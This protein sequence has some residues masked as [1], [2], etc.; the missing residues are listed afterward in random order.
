V[1]GVGSGMQAGRQAAPARGD[2]A[3]ILAVRLHSTGEVVVAMPMLFVRR[4][5]AALAAL[6]SLTALPALPA[7][8]QRPIDG[9]PQLAQ[10]EQCHALL[11]SEPQASL[12]LARRL[13]E[14]PSLSTS[15]EIGAVGCLGAALRGLGQLEQDSALPDRLLAAAARADATPADRQRARSMAAHLLLWSGER[16]RALSLTGGLLDDAVKARDVQGQISALMQIAM[17]R[18]DAMGDAEGALTYL[19][20]ATVLSDHLHRPP[21][22]G[23]LIL[24]YNYGYALLN[25]ERHAEAAAA[26]KRA[27]AIGTRLA[28][29]E[30]FLNRIASHRAEIQRVAGLLDPAEAGLRRVLAWQAAQDPQ[31]QVVT[32][33][34]LARLALDRGHVAAALP[35]ATQAQGLAERGHFIEEVRNGLDLL[36]D[37]HTLLGHRD[38]A[39]DYV[40]RGRALDKA[41]TQGETLGALARLQA[42]AERG[43]DPAQVNAEQDLGRVRLLRNSAVIALVAVGVLATVMVLRLRHQR[44]RLTVLSRTDAVTGL[45]NRLEAERRLDERGA[46][47]EGGARSALLLIE[48]DDFKALNE[49]YGQAAGDSVL[50]S[51]AA[52]LRA[53]CDRHDLLARWSGAAFLVARHDTCPDAAQALAA[54]LRLAIERLVVDA[55]PQQHLTLTASVGV[56]PLPLFGD[57]AAVLDD[58][59][60]AAD[61][62]LQGARHSGRNAWAAVWGERA[63]TAGQ[64]HALLGDPEGAAAAGWL[65]L[66]GSPS[67]RW[68][69]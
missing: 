58:S 43:I 45:L 14:A 61:R 30:L 7:L 48:L 46:Q 36:G 39:L 42:S 15:M 19:H 67:I 31:G 51:V 24:Y 60:R 27:E 22:P 41:R 13:L 21:N 8:A 2:K 11:T 12:A 38:Q 57:A 3:C 5:L 68:A 33:Q 53:A 6:L 37:I 1:R 65:R 34:R 26:F 59:L 64:L 10:V 47:A 55:G 23:D 20:K 29:Q 32:L 52:C 40:R 35:L 63:G 28:G 44:R 17:I 18:G 25:L 56:A 9:P 50:R 62:A 49:R 66:S 16:A 69:P 4:S 54:H